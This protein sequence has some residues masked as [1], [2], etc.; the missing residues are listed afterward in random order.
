MIDGT[1]TGVP[2]GKGASVSI[3]RSDSPPRAS[4]E[5]NTRSDV[6]G[7]RELGWVCQVDISSQSVDRLNAIAKFKAGP[8]GA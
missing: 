8:K 1:D 6:L 5:K 3:H 4:R 2:F 7:P